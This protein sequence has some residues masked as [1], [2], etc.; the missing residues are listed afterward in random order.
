MEHKLIISKNLQELLEKVA[1]D[2]ERIFYLAG[3]TDINIQLKK[4]MIKTKKIY[5]INNLKELRFLKLKDNLLKIG[6]LTTFGEIINSK[7][8]NNK[9][10]FLPNALK[11]FASPLLQNIATIGGNI[12]NGSP[13]ADIIP[14]LL[15]LDAKLLLCSKKEERTVALNDFFTGYK[16]NLLQKIEIIKAI[17]IDVKY[18]IEPFYKKVSSRKS[19][20]IAKISICAI[21][22]K[23][24]GKIVDF[25]I[26]VGSLNEYA[27]RLTKLEEYLNEGKNISKEGINKTLKKEIFPISD[28]RSDSEYRFQVCQNLVELF[29]SKYFKI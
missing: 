20:T 6:A 26:A 12:A 4:K 16:K 15:A 10:P 9:I 8:I 18:N 11:N 28:L 14:I 7:L 23:E 21:A 29:V 27:R 5:F 25:K 13:T 24:N 2:N 3:G 19:L 22:T 17:L 1:H